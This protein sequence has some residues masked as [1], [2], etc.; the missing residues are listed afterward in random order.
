MRTSL[1]ESVAWL[2]IEITCLLRQADDEARPSA[3]RCLDSHFPAMIFGD[4]EI[5]DG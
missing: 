3:F 4:D 2:R 5:G 1:T